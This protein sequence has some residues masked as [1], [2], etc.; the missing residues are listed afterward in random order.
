MVFFVAYVLL[1][2]SKL[3]V[4]IYVVVHASF[5]LYF[6]PNFLRYCHQSTYCRG[7]IQFDMAKGLAARFSPFLLY[8]PLVAVRTTADD[9]NEEAYVLKTRKAEKKS[10]AKYYT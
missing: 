1:T 7:G 8:S 4:L 2:Q 3:V 5:L 10:T 6:L 9:K